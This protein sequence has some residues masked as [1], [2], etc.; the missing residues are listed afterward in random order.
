LIVECERVKRRGLQH[1]EDLEC[2]RFFD[3]LGL[4]RAKSGV[5][6]KPKKFDV[7]KFIKANF[8]NFHLKFCSAEKIFMSAFVRQTKL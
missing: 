4:E 6:L 8:S 7:Q 5:F 1:R 2:R 3:G